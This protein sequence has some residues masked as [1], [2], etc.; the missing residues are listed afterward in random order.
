MFSSRKR[1]ERA[2]YQHLLVL[3]RWMGNEENP[4][5]PITVAM[6]FSPIQLF[7]IQNGVAV[8]NTPICFQLKITC[9][10]AFTRYF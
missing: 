4:A 1:G 2:N 8:K 10:L 3:L 5:I 9:P 7:F 6:H